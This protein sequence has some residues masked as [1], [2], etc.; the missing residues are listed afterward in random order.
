MN[1]STLLSFL[2]LAIAGALVII[3]ARGAT[4]MRHSMDEDANG[5]MTATELGVADKTATGTHDHSAHG[6]VGHG[7]A[8]AASDGHMHGKIDV[9]GEEKAPDLEIAMTR[10]AVSGWNL[11]ISTTHF[12]FAPYNANGKHVMGEGHAHIYINGKKY[13]RVYGPWFHIGALEK[14]VN[15]VEVTLN[16]NGHDAYVLGDKP[17][18]RKVTI[19]ER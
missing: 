12:R 14:G 5:A 18:S 16:G 4:G 2:G 8:D 13:A 9:S 1:R 7:D 17:V 15:H 10:D 3:A 19:T 6:V 11:Q